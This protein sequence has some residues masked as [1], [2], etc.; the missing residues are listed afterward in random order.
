MPA[1]MHIAVARGTRL[2]AALGLGSLV[3]NASRMSVLGDSKHKEDDA[4]SAS[5]L[6]T[7]VSC[8]WSGC[9]A[10]LRGARCVQVGNVNIFPFQKL[11]CLCPAKSCAHK[12]TKVCVQAP[13]GWPVEGHMEIETTDGTYGGKKITFF[14]NDVLER[15]LPTAPP[16]F[17]ES[18]KGV[19]WLDEHGYYGH[20]DLQMPTG[21][22]AMTFYEPGSLDRRKRRVSLKMPGPSWPFPNRGSTYRKVTE[23]NNTYEFEF[24]DNYSYAKVFLRSQATVVLPI[25]KAILEFDMVL[26]PRPADGLC[27]PKPDASK[28][29]RAKCAKWNR[30]VKTGDAWIT[31]YPVYEIVDKHGRRVQ[32][33]YDEYL[34][35]QNWL[36]RTDPPN[37][38]GAAQ[39]GVR[40][41]RVGME[42]GTSFFPH[43]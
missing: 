35:F 29:D 36:V 38:A 34:A 19:L 15:V 31:S 11:R 16:D 10:S 24:N 20:S 28:K 8:R 17:P 22:Y 40:L 5:E 27:P 13:R 2:C 23:Y 43:Y 41:G 25:F 33:Y 39:A 6:D 42:L 37:A 4:C 1:I 7:G 3:A 18:L 21:N 26:N 12:K 32:P 30:L 9:S 14:R